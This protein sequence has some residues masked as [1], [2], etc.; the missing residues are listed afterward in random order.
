MCC[1][2]EQIC[3]GSSVAIRQTDWPPLWRKDYCQG[4]FYVVED[5][6]EY[7]CKQSPCPYMG[8]RSGQ[9]KTKALRKT[10]SMLTGVI[11]GSRWPRPNSPVQ[12]R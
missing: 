7:R 10:A 8:G 11:F 9:L 4:W 3:F 6:C 5:V 2:V 12:S 1:E